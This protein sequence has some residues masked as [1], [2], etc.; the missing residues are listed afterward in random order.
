[1]RKAIKLPAFVFCFI[2]VAVGAEAQEKR[3]TPALELLNAARLADT[4]VV[5]TQSFKLHATIK[6]EQ[7]KGV[8]TEGSYVLIWSSPTQWRE[9]FLLSDFHQVRVSGPG[10]IWEER[11]PDFLSL[12]MWQLMQAL[13]YYGRFKLQSEESADKVKRK[14]KNASEL[15]CVEIARHS[16]PVREFCF[17]GDVVELASEHYLPSNRWYE[18]TDYRTIGTKLFPGHIRVFDGK[19]LAADFSVSKME[20]PD[21]LSTAVFEH[22]AQAKWRPWCASPEAGGDPLTPIFSGLIH[23]KGTAIFYG[24]IGADGRWNNVHVLESG[25]VRHDAE[26]LEAQKKERWKPTSCSGVPI[27]VE[28]V[29]RR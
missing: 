12:R 9:E 4:H 5:S 29:F 8:E 27:M 23:E 10:G 13:G 22:S 25:G 18:F 26:V 19:I 20:V 28:T 21:S 7:G 6:L 17:R 3:P 16:N 15:R 11:E 2:A 24:A 14:K 1:V